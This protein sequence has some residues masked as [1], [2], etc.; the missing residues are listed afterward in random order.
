MV[1]SLSCD[2]AAQPGLLDT[3]AHHEDEYTD[4]APCQ[5]LGQTGFVVKG[6]H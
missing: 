6:R 2:V 5:R 1:E 3:V 4:K